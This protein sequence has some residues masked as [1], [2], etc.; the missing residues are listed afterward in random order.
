MKLTSVKTITPV[1]GMGLLLSFSG[2]ADRIAFAPERGATVTRTMESRMT[3]DLED[4]TMDVDGQDMTAMMGGLP[5]MSMTFNNSV[6]VEDKFLELGDRRPAR[7]KRTFEAISSSAVVDVSMMG[8]GESNETEMSSE[9][10]GASV[11]FTW[12]EETGEYTKS[13][14]DEDEKR[15]VELLEGLEEDMDLRAFLPRTEVSAGESWDIPYEA[16][17]NLVLPGGFLG[18]TPEG[19]DEMDSD[20]DMSQVEEMMSEMFE[21]YSD[22]LETLFAGERKATYQGMREID[23]AT[24]A[25]ITLK[26]DTDGTLDLSSMITDMMDRMS[27][28]MD[29]PM[30]AD[31]SIAAADFSMTIDGAGELL[32]NPRTGVFASM[33]MET[34]MTMGME[35]SVDAD[36]GGEATTLDMTMEMA[37]DMETSF[38]NQ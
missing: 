19:M 15:D 25:V 9:L 27:D 32:W 1:V 4:F 36:M 21:Q 30:E 14:E 10:E 23:G 26:L 28:V 20:M 2:T 22:M 18:A 35:V 7:L 17:M 38:T 8:E 13:Y 3:I 33:S 11:I 5:E 12:D 29:M 37:G 24:Y 6:T 34:D 16:L 31:I